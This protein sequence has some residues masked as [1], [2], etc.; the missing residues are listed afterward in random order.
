MLGIAKH[1]ELFDDEGGKDILNKEKNMGRMETALKFTTAA[2]LSVALA[3]LA[4]G[5]IIA[6]G[7]AD[8]TA[9]LKQIAGIDLPGPPGKR[10]DYLV[11]DYD[12]GWLFSAHLAA[13]QTYVIDLKSNSV[14]HVIADTSWRRRNQVRSRRTQGLH[15]ECRRRYRRRR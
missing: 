12:D 14:L 13:N 2:L 4:N 10:F 15:L 6:V 11:I 3:F 9:V 8:D 7:A 5:S 1:D